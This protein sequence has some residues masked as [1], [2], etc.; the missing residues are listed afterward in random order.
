MATCILSACCGM[1][2]NVC[3]LETSQ[4]GH[5]EFLDPRREITQMDF[6]EIFSIHSGLDQIQHI[7]TAPRLS[8][9]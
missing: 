9:R 5:F 2:T 1:N 6:S 4:C 3:V 7:R 8:R